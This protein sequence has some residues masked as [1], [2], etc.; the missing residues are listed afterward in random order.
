[1]LICFKVMMSFCDKYCCFMLF[2][3]FTGR[4]SKLTEDFVPLVKMH[5]FDVYTTLGTST[6]YI[7]EGEI[8]KCIV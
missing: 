6:F 8:P 7:F 2:F 4:A 3:F 5:I 1:M